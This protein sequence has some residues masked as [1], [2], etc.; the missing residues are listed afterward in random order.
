MGAISRLNI[1]GRLGL[2]FGFVLFLMLTLTV[3]SI[4]SVNGINSN[5]QVVN[6]VNSVK[7]PAR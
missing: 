6:D 5:L 4:S 7:Q 1:M 3:L 2:G